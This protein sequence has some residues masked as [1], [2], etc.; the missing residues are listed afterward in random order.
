MVEPRIGT[1]PIRERSG[2]ILSPKIW[3]LLGP[4]TTDY[5]GR[6]VSPLTSQPHVLVLNVGY[7]NCYLL[8]NKT[9]NYP[10]GS[11]FCESWFV[12]GD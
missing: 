8:L 4:P 9:L 12:L 5:V 11:Q 1:L 3:V 6:V 10:L 7:I 2:S